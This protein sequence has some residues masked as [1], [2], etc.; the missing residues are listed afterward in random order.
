MTSRDIRK[1]TAKVRRNNEKQV[2]KEAKSVIRTLKAD[3]KR[4]A[5][6]GISDFHVKIR[7]VETYKRARIYFASKGFR[8]WEYTSDGFNYLAI[9][10]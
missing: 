2:Q 1:I 8:C 3:I 7:D 6:K 10:W 4:V 5:K 9:A